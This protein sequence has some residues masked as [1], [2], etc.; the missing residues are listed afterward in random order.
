MRYLTL[1]ADYTQ[2]ALRDDLLGTVVPEEVGLSEA[3]GDSIRDWSARY[4][5][6]IPLDEGER[7]QSPAAELIRSLDEEGLSLATQI[8]A[9]H[10]AFKVR[11]YSEGLLRYVP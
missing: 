11:Y 3:L 1:A 2:S 5:A 7:A 9:A 10:P 4:R 6:I 8:A